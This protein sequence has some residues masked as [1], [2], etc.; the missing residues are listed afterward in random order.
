MMD[1]RIEFHLLIF[2]CFSFFD[3]WKVLE[4]HM[5][6]T[7]KLKSVSFVMEINARFQHLAFFLDA[8]SHAFF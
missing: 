8:R 3:D 2:F 6:A 4:K 1:S 5:G 7:N